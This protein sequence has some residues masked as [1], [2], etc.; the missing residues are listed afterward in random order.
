MNQLEQDMVQDIK[1]QSTTEQVN[2]LPFTSTSH[3][4][5]DVNNSNSAIKMGQ[6]KP[7][8]SDNIGSKLLMKMGWKKGESLG[9]KND[10]LKEPISVVFR[11]KGAGL[12]STKRRL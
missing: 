3:T 8:G 7:I 10:G 6:S 2:K 1:N 12:G 5:K 11:T 4:K 9:L